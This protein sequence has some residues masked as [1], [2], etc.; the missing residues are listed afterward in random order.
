MS[1]NI[2]QHSLNHMEDSTRSHSSERFSWSREWAY[3]QSRWI[4]Q[5]A[6]P[7]C[8]SLGNLQHDDSDLSSSPRPFHVAYSLASPRSIVMHC[9][10]PP[11]KQ[12][13]FE[14]CIGARSTH[15]HKNLHRLLIQPY[16][17]RA[18]SHHRQVIFT[19]PMLNEGFTSL[20]GYL[21]ESQG[22]SWSWS[23]FWKFIG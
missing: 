20:K 21:H 9:R 15:H 10:T 1:L 4:L 7:S 23:L 17:T 19:S 14:G 5:P 11:I 22:N 18:W 6:H 3:G 13:P 12:S 8:T 16:L 2:H